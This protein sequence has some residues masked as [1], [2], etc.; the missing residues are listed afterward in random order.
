MIPAL[1]TAI[2]QDPSL[3]RYQSTDGQPMASYF[4]SPLWLNVVN[5][6]MDVIKDNV[7][8]IQHISYETWMSPF[9]AERFIASV[10]RNYPEVVRN[11]EPETLVRML[12]QEDTPE[13]LQA[14]RLHYHDLIHAMPSSFFRMVIPIFPRL[15]SI[16]LPLESVPLLFQN[17]KVFIA[18]FWQHRHD[19][20]VMNQIFHSIPERATARLNGT[21]DEL[22]SAIAKCPGD[23]W[24]KPLRTFMQ[25]PLVPSYV[26]KR[27]MGDI[28]YAYHNLAIVSP[29]NYVERL[30]FAIRCLPLDKAYF[31]EIA[32]RLFDG[33]DVRPQLTKSALHP[34]HADR[35]A[36]ALYLAITTYS[37][38]TM[39]RLKRPIYP[40][41]HDNIKRGLE[42]I[43]TPAV[44]GKL[45]KRG[46]STKFFEFALAD[47][48]D[49]KK[50]FA[51]QTHLVAETKAADSNPILLAAAQ[52]EFGPLLQEQKDAS[53]GQVA[54]KLYQAFC[55]TGNL[56]Y[57]DALP[58]HLSFATWQEIGRLCLSDATSSNQPVPLLIP[59]DMLLQE[60]HEFFRTDGKRVANQ[61]PLIRYQITNS[62]YMV[63]WF[64]PDAVHAEVPVE[65]RAQGPLSYTGDKVPAE[66][67]R[68]LA[69]D[70]DIHPLHCSLP[71]RLF[72]SFANDE[73]PHDFERKRAA[74]VPRALRIQIIRRWAQ[75]WPHYLWPTEYKIVV[76]DLINLLPGVNDI[77]A[78]YVYL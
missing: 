10:M 72:L 27:I 26:A 40:L 34:C 20:N 44:Y 39:S 3:V 64:V 49:D 29:D 51:E 53:P 55:V 73:S 60:A 41:L 32:A 23:E 66:F 74:P 2:R 56:R 35:W 6:V 54:A 52:L 71:S 15:V 30:L 43:V 47:S 45:L 68:F 1:I 37:C 9:H 13:L 62:P 33:K 50:L 18:Y 31:F 36:G 59:A 38:Y 14:V 12:Q 58:S 67:I 16:G 78:A 46:V 25:H 8:A 48:P 63:S 19:P 57:W 11:I 76:A 21:L 28:N 75:Y 17:A 7:F 22:F 70:S 77:I 42:V 65:V 4:H 69:L 5:G 24:R 61:W